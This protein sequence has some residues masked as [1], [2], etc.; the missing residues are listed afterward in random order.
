M[1]SGGYQP[2]IIEFRIAESATSRPTAVAN[3]GL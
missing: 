1:V 3:A 2:V